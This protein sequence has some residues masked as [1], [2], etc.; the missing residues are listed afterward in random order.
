MSSLKKFT[1]NKTLVGG[2]T[3]THLKSIFKKMWN[4]FP[5][6]FG[7]EKFQKI[8]WVAC[9][10]PSKNCATLNFP[11]FGFSPGRPGPSKHRIF[12]LPLSSLGNWL[13][14]SFLKVAAFSGTKRKTKGLGN[15]G[16]ERYIY[17][18]GW[19]IFVGIY[20]EASFFLKHWGKKT[21]SHNHGVFRGK[22]VYLQY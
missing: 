2:W 21:S 7:G 22:W 15:H 9:H 14:S 6:R 20:W 4:S 13:G 3:P 11:F 19:L 10:H 12:I 16:D 5:P 1:P 18:H 8:I 17:L